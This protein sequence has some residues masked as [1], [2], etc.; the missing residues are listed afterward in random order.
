MNEA[1][2]PADG[3]KKGRSVWQWHIPVAIVGTIL[4][5]LALFFL[6]GVVPQ[7]KI[8]SNVA[9][10]RADMRTL[11]TAIVSY[12]ADYMIYPAWG[13]GRPGPGNVRTYND[14]IVEKTGNRSGVGDLP[15]FLLCDSTPDGVHFAMLTTGPVLSYSFAGREFAARAHITKY[16]VDPFCRDKGATF[17]YWSVVPGRMPADNKYAG[18]G[19]I[20]W[21][22]VSPGPD[23]DYDLP[24]YFYY[25]GRVRQPSPL[26]LG[27]TNSKGSAFTYD[28]TN[29]LISD[30]DIWRISQ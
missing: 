16:P 14:M 20:G 9:R 29:G 13:I 6:F 22:L 30:G 19:G 17:V 3:E 25:D 12:A 11:E 24:G 5:G 18:A 28:P 2:K 21:I 10:V 7:Y 15:T 1:S 23:G 4:G 26:L 27:G 8:K